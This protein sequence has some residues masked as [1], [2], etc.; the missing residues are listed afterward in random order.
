MMFEP[1][2]IPD[3]ATDGPLDLTG[4]ARVDA[5]RGVAAEEVEEP[6]GGL[7]SMLRSR[8]RALLT[9]LLRPYR[10]LLSLRSS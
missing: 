5:W 1:D 9:S 8:S 10:R 7:A 2:E 4:D 3:I 6:G